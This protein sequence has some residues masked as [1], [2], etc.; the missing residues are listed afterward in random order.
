MRINGPEF[1]INLMLLKESYTD[2]RVKKVFEYWKQ[3]FDHNCFIEDAA[4]YEWQNAVDFMVQEEAAMYLMGQFIKDS[5]PDELESD[6]D[7]FRFPII[8]PA[9]PIGEDAP[10]DG[11]SSR[12][13]PATWKAA[14]NSWLSSAPRKF[15]RWPLK[16]WAACPPAPTSIFRLRLLTCRR[17]WR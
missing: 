13:T 1:H 17:V 9:M 15:S 12:P 3:L 4:A 7:F 14:K 6:L 11:F 16:K 5:Y 2:E 8:D 10:T